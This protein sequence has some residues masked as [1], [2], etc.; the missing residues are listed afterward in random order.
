MAATGKVTVGG[1]LRWGPDA[2]LFNLDSA[3]TVKVNDI[4]TVLWQEGSFYYIK[5]GSGSSLKKMYIPT[6]N[7]TITSDSVGTPFISENGVRYTNAPDNTRYADSATSP[8]AGSLGAYEPVRYTG[9]KNGDYALL[10]YEVTGPYPTKRKRAWFPHMKM[11]N[12]PAPSPSTVYASTSSLSSTH[13][14]ANAKYICSYLMSLGFGKKAACAVLG[15][16]E[17]ESATVNPGKWQVLNSLSNGYGLV[18]WT[19]ATHFLDR[20]AK[21]GIISSATA[22]QANA[23]ATSNP[24]KLMDAELE[25]LM[26]FCASTSDGWNGPP[27]TGWH[28]T[29]RMTFSQFKASTETAYNLAIVF[30]DYYERSDDTLAMI[31]TNRCTKAQY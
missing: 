17:W 18:Q 19:P 3:S 2:S 23:L 13:M 5:I 1:S 27:A 26:Y 24:K 25:C 28:T 30:H 4:V 9:K 11:M 20:A 21:D 14:A 16:M 10:E 22:A 8:T 6:T 7:V 29:L 12:A 15:N 31:Q